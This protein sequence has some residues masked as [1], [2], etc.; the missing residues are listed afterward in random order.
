MRKRRPQARP[1]HAEHGAPLRHVVELHHP[2]RKREGV[3]V[4]QRDD[5][6]AEADMAGPLGGGGDEQFRAG[7]D[8]EP[9]GMVLADPDLVVVEPVEMLDQFHIPVEAGGR[10]LV[11]RVKRSEED[12][13]AE[14]GGHGDSGPSGR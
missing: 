11:H 14:R 1:A 5:A 3:V 7:D 10:V 4:G 9:A 8:L 6:G 2:V 13:E 12:S